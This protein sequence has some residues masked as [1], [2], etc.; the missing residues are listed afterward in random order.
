MVRVPKAWPLANRTKLAE[1]TSYPLAFLSV[2]PADIPPVGSSDGVRFVITQPGEQIL[3]QSTVQHP[4]T[5]ARPGGFRA[6]G[7][8]VIWG[9][10]Q[11]FL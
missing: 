5:S 10:I 1:E 8:R 6:T 9:Y 2:T 3:N 4:A 7:W 11:F